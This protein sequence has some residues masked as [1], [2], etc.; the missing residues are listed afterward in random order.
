MIDWRLYRT[1]V[2]AAVTLAALYVVGWVVAA[3]L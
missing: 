1:I 3:W 2:L